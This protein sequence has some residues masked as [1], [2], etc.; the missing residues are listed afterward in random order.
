[1]PTIRVAQ[2]SRPVVVFSEE[3]RGVFAVCR[4]LVKLL[5]DLLQE[6]LR[7]ICSNRALAAEVRL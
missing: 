5:I 6:L 2:S 4:I 7:L 1:M 3:E